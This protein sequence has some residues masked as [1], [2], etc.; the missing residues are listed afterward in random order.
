MQRIHRPEDLR[1][2]HA[3]ADGPISTHV[4]S[5]NPAR[6]AIGEGAEVRIHIRDDFPNHEVLPVPGHRRVHIPGTA[7]WS[8][9]IQS[10]EDDFTYNVGGDGMVDYTADI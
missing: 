3:E 8:G 1:M 4:V 5:N 2:R 7:K 9:H 6:V 10:D